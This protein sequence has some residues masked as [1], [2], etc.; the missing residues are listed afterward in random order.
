MHRHA[1]VLYERI[2]FMLKRI[3][4]TALLLVLTAVLPAQAETAWT[5]VPDVLRPGK[6]TRIAF[7]ADA[8]T[9]DI[10]VMDDTGRTICVVREGVRVTEGENAFVWDGSGVERGQWTLRLTSGSDVAEVQ[11]TVGMDAPQLALI[12]AAPTLENGWYGVVRA[13]VPGRLTLSVTVDGV[14][15]E[16]AACEAYAGENTIR[17]D[18]LVDGVKPPEGDHNVMLRL[19][20]GMGFTSTAAVVSVYSEGPPPPAPARDAYLIAPNHFSDTVCDHDVCYWK[21]NMGELNEENIWQVLTQPVTVLKGHD[22][23]R[24]A[25]RREPDEKCTDYVGEVTCASQA[26][27]I[28]ERGEEWTLI[29]AYS[30][31]TAYSNI[32]IYANYMKG[33]VKTDLLEEKPVS[34][35]F[36]I[37]IDKL[38]QRLYL[39]VDGKHVTT[40][41]CSTGYATKNDPYNETPAGEFIIVSWTGGF[42]SGNLYCDMALRVNGGILLHEVPCIMRTNAQGEEYRVYDYCEQV[43]GEKASHGCI[44]VQREL[45]P[46]GYN[47]EWLWENLKLGTKVIIWDDVGRVLDYPEDDLLVFYNPDKGRMYHSVANCPSVASRFLPL[48]PITYGELSGEE[49]DHLTPCPYCDPEPSR[50][51][52]DKVNSQTKKNYVKH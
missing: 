26:V 30:S 15:Y 31:C 50:E 19:T 43:L 3:I 44:R 14:A 10:T 11:V 51:M 6:L 40:L 39:F 48:A 23:K 41:L 38:R 49:F 34:Q 17:W 20:D 4:L 12:S 22:R 5:S 47:M 13:N 18:G 21:L 33:W 36:G 46:E 29:E 37:V 42:W 28:L 16:V 35:K 25:I 2:H 7:E 8:E 1:F 45:S 9:A 24:I 52:I 32:K 27:H